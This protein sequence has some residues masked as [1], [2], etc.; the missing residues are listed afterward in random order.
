M[1][2][3]FYYSTNVHAHAHD[4]NHSEREA[5]SYYK[6][7]QIITNY[8]LDNNQQL[9]FFSGF[10]QRKK[11]MLRMEAFLVADTQ[12]YKRLCLSVRRSVRWSIH[13]VH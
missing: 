8:Y 9:I 4:Y 13:H 1:E 3:F 5:F 12:L 11:Y 7:L 2:A 6:H 10:K